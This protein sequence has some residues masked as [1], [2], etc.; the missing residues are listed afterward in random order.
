LA[1]QPFDSVLASIWAQLAQKDSDDDA[2][3]LMR[4]AITAWC[5]GDE[6]AE[7]RAGC[8]ESDWRHRLGPAASRRC[9]ARAA[10]R[11]RRA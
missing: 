3:R 11:A 6:N 8:A 4:A 7:A 10:D 2:S 5:N 9:G 1:H